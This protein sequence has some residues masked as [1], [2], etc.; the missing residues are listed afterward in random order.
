MDAVLPAFIDIREIEQ[1]LEIRQYLKSA[2]ADLGDDCKE[3][4]HEEIICLLD[5]CDNWLKSAS[6]ADL[7]AMM[8]SFISLILVCTNERE[9]I[10]QKFCSKITDVGATEA[11]AMLRLRILGC[12]FAGLNEDCPLRYEVYCS[13]L[14][15]ATQFGLT[16]NVETKLKE[17]SSWL[18]LWNLD[19]EKKRKC[20]RLLHSA[21]KDSKNSNEATKVMLEIL[22][23][24]D[25]RSA[26][27]AKDDALQCILHCINKPD[28]FIMDHL[29]QLKPVLALEGQ[30]IL[31]LLKIFVSGKL[32]DYMDFFEKNSNF[33][34][35]LPGVNHEGNIN[36]MKILTLVS[37]A[38]EQS[39]IEFGP[40]AKQLLLNEDEVEEFV[41]EAVKSDLFHAKLDQVNEKVILDSS[42]RRT[43][44]RKE[45]E[46]LRQKLEQWRENL[47]T[48]KGQ[49]EQ[50]VPPV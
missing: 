4:I 15:L 19:I 50:V 13:Q 44:E 45:W 23:T 26:T 7:E 30:P 49:L 28:V 39:E 34:L 21:L 47:L 43:F 5:V 16:D 38:R 40:L 10:T 20:Y 27:E 37:I 48:I 18:E 14:K 46:E 36:K 22:G 3:N 9:K 2:G 42:N 25:D 33:V 41:I 12:F 32:Q 31:K 29:L 1:A 35:G 8:N 6:D 17:A 11:N 24:Y